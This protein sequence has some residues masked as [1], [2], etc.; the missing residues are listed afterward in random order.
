MTLYLY[1]ALFLVWIAFKRLLKLN[2]AFTSTTIVASAFLLAFL[3]NARTSNAQLI[4]HL[5]GNYTLSEVPLAIK[6]P[7]A[8][9]GLNIPANFV[10]RPKAAAASLEHSSLL[11][12]AQLPDITG[13]NVENNQAFGRTTASGDNPL[14]T[15]LLQDKRETGWDL[16]A[17]S[18]AYEHNY[19]EYTYAKLGEVF[20]LQG[21]R[22]VPPSVGRWRWKNIYR[23]EVKGHLL[24]SVICDGT[25]TVP[26]PRCDHLFLY[27]NIIVKLNFN[28]RS[29]KSW[30]YIEA[31]VRNKLESWER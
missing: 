25:G 23:K 1:A 26:Y 16:A 30:V 4:P 19:Q 15:I 22:Q 6:F 24:T 20:G 13:R 29:L 14:I 17:V 28:A 11:L 8:G 18:S 7:K 21:R 27:K 12:M 5:L 3:V 31:N 9:L 2:V 10:D